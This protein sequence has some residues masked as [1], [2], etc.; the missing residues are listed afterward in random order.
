MERH[1]LI[2]NNYVHAPLRFGEI[3]LIQLGRRY[4]RPSALIETVHADYFELTVVLSGKGRI[5]TADT[6]VEVSKGDIHLAGPHELHAIKP[7]SEEPVRYDFFAFHP[8]NE[9]VYRLLKEALQSRPT[10]GERI[11]RSESIPPLIASGIRELQ[12][13]SYGWESLLEHLFAQITV[14]LVR[15]FL[16]SIA[17]KSLLDV[18]DSQI[19]CYQAMNYIDTHL[20]RLHY[21]SE[22]AEAFNYNYSYLS[23]LF[24]RVTG[25]TMNE[26]LSDGR[27]AA[28]R[29][30]LEKGSLSVGAIAEKWNYPSLSSFSRAFKHRFGVSP[31]QYRRELENE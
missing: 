27:L 26:Y 8:E 22:V 2:D 7:N 15:A 21:L 29:A 5:R 13:R 23:D 12:T 3:T 25:Q 19:L 1:F 31:T 4:S 14:Y 20:D 30:E 11:F 9:E 10:A 16:P 18:T 24:H 6:E 17:Q 28:C